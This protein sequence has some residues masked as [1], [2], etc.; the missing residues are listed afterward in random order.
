M[1]ILLIWVIAFVLIA[2]FANKR[3]D[4]GVSQGLDK[5]LPGV[6]KTHGENRYLWVIALAVL[7][8]TTLIRPV[9]ILLVVILLAIIGLIIAKL[10]NWASN[11]V[12]H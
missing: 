3:W 11:K 1:T 8:A 10:A 4:N 5:M 6:L 12:T 2:Y 9:D 7:G